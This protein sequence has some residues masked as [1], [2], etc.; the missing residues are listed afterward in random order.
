MCLVVLKR[1]HGAAGEDD[2]SGTGRDR[3]KC[4]RGGQEQVRKFDVRGLPRHLLKEYPPLDTKI[5]QC[6]EK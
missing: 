3:R 4:V 6:E 5:G 2:G 1:R